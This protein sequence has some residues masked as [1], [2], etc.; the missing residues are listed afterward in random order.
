M[1][2]TEDASW[3]HARIGLKSTGSFG[4]RVLLAALLVLAMLVAAGVGAVPYAF[5]AGGPQPIGMSRLSTDQT[6]FFSPF[7]CPA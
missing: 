7:V 2:V 4:C 6:S 5:M 3:R 1:E